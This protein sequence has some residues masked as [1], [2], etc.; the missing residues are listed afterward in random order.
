MAKQIVAVTGSYRRGG[1]IDQAVAEAAKAARES[2]AEVS[3]INL[4][5]K[6]IEFCTNCRVC[7]QATGEKR[8]GCPLKDDMN[9]IL[10][11]LEAADGYILAA[12]VNFFNVTAI[13]RRFMER[14]TPYAY[15]V[16]GQS[17]PRFRIKG[18]N[19]K[20]VVITSSAMP[21]IMGR[22]FTGAIRA[23]KGAAEPLGAKYS[24]SLFIGFAAGAEK[25]KLS[26]TDA[27]LAGKLGR[28][29]AS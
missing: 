14:L 11:E 24:G 12:P 29:L 8:G 1:I 28:G 7:T 13:F 17:A 20:A 4:L 25:P 18:K 5:D 10:D 27:R 2:G 6:H 23:L 19:K 3:V 22:I 26:E 9:G 15:W 21:S 16:W